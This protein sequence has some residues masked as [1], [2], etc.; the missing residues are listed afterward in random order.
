MAYPTYE[1]Q[2]RKIQEA[3]GADAQ[4]IRT[5]EGLFEVRVLFD[6]YAEEQEQE[7]D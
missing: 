7:E 3:F 4:L 1:V 6:G 5:E 2:L